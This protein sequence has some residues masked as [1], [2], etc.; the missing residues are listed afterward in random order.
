MK[1]LVFLF[2][3]SISTI[4]YGQTQSP[5]KEFAIVLSRDN[6]Q[7][8]AN[9]TREV[10]ITINRSKSY[11]KSS[12]VMGLSSPLPKGVEI[13]FSPDKGTFETTTLQVKTNEAVVPG[14]YSLVISAKLNGKTKGSIIKL[15]ITDKAIASD[16]NK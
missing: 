2:F 15:N 11:L 4:G 12:A 1:P 5:N 3:L 14:S 16:G 9:E 8:S 6:V 10:E 13:S 7:L